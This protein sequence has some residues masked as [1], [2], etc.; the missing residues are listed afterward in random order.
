MAGIYLNIFIKFLTLMILIIGSLICLWSFILKVGFNKYII[1]FIIMIWNLNFLYI[2]NNKE[3]L[4]LRDKLNLIDLEWVERVEVG[5]WSKVKI[6]L[7]NWYYSKFKIYN[8]K[9]QISLIIV[10]VMFY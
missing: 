4:K 5:I 8:I 10:F 9:I 2:C 7:T 3:I 1:I 6:Y